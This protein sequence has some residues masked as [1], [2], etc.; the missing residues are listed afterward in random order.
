MKLSDQQWEHLQ[1]I[2]KLV[3]WAKERG[4]KLTVAD[5]T[6]DEYGKARYQHSPIGQH[7]KGLAVD[8]NLFIDGTYRS[9]EA[10]HV[11]MGAY[12]ES[13]HEDCRWGGRYQDANH[14]EFVPG[15]RETIS[16]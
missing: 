7:P 11:A 3:I 1:A 9:D 10:A 15:W 6:T 14:Y 8:L 2:A 12:W 4:Y 5:W 16:T 13:L